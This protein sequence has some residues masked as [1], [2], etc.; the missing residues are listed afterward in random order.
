MPLLTLT[1]VAY[2]VVIIVLAPVLYLFSA[3]R[4]AAVLIAGVFSVGMIILRITH[5]PA[6]NRTGW[7]LIAVAAALMTVG[8]AIFAVA[9]TGVIEAAEFPGRTDLFFLLAY[10][11]LAVGVLRL[12]GWRAY[13][14]LPTI[15]DI[16]L[17]SLAGSLLIWIT[18]LRPG[19]TSEAEST[20][21]ISVAIASC[22]GYVA[23][24]AAAIAALAAA[25]GRGNVLVIAIGV[26]AFL[27]ANLVFI[28]ARV[29]DSWGVSVGAG[30]LLLASVVAAGVATF[31][32][33]REP[34]VARRSSRVLR[35]AT[36][37]TIA[38]GLLVA[39]T[40]LLVEATTGAVNTATAIGVIAAVEAVLVLARLGVSVAESRRRAARNAI[41]R[42]G[43]RRLA[44]AA[45][46]EEILAALRDALHGML[47]PGARSG[48]RLARG[49]P[50]GGTTP[51][52]LVYPLDSRLTDVVA[53]ERDD[54]PRR[55]AY[56]T[57]PPRDLAEVHPSV[58]SLLDQAGVALARID[59]AGR[60][61]DQDRE[62]FFQR[63]VSSSEEVIL[64]SREDRIEYVSPSADRMFGRDV[65][66]DRF[67]DLVRTPAG[68]RRTWSDAENGREA[69][70]SRPGGGGATVLVYRRDLRDDPTIRGVITT[71]HDV[72]AEREL[73]RDLEH[74]AT[75]D[76]LTGLAN[77]ALFRGSVR[78]G[79][80]EPDRAVLVV[81]VDDFK[82]VN[83]TFGHHVGDE[84][85]AIVAARITAG[86]RNVDLAARIGGDEFAV[87]LRAVDERTATEITRRISE[88]LGQPASV[89]ET[90]VNTRSSIGLALASVGDDDHTLLRNADTALYVAKAAG[91]GR[92]R[93]YTA[94]MP[95]PSRQRPEVRN[96]MAAA[97]SAGELTLHYA[98][99]VDLASGHVVGFEGLPRMADDGGPMSSAEIAKAADAI[100]RAAE[101]GDWVLE[102]A[103]HDLPRLN[104]SGSGSGSGS[105]VG[106]SSSSGSGFGSDPGFGSASGSGAS[107]GFSCGSSSGS[108]SGF[109]NGDGR[110][111]GVDVFSRQL[112][113]PD[114]AD[115]VRRAIEAADADPRRL[116]LEI[117]EA[118]LG[119]DTDRAW[120]QLDELSAAG[121][122]VALDGYGTGTA[123]LSH[124]RQPAIDV[125]K[126]DASFL[127]DAGSPRSRQLLAAI[128]D[129][130]GT[131]R[132]EQVAQGVHDE[133][134]CTTLRDLGCAYA[135]GPLFG[136]AVPV[137][138]AETWR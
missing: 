23:V 67:D 69:S 64:I 120:N 52:E 78:E 37:F 104:G 102:R 135:Q 2:L 109:G 56:V 50:V 8:D 66:G 137:D 92:W 98:P 57:A 16:S 123:S 5:G 131:L 112:R 33:E 38:V 65:H 53:D 96:R 35:P 119:E 97:L 124:L 21:S 76:P 99:I 84:L 40:V 122:R 101:L 127:A 94:G 63:I 32:P 46:E 134:G 43:L 71:L 81:D 59:L 19:L 26:A 55:T 18:V 91:K 103:L 80:G 86:I 13:R 42:I 10:F 39:P 11:P 113:Q 77:A 111:V 130:A 49:D 34:P 75:H 108:G 126:L 118:E 28:R 106:S 136:P 132:L 89:A 68:D 85:L 27:V 93:Q 25:R 79:Q 48:V 73:R 9:T 95:A 129:L 22:V 110:F 133:A 36:L 83:D 128:T 20:F 70:I 121:V 17:L 72:T 30:F 90:L 14:S 7:I 138:V 24:L 74:R 51:G 82:I 61:N 3:T 15:I 1:R 88:A 41:A 115:R 107:S 12:A 62:R 100:G 31:F 105:G 125:I 60:L 117:A 87:L 44:L 4:V 114:F 58:V 116:V 45:N 29:L 47:P 6:R 54:A